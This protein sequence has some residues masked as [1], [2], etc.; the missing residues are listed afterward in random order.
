MYYVNGEY[1]EGEWDNDSQNGI[2]T[3]YNK[4]GTIKEY[5]TWVDG[6]CQG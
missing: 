6:T 4:D 1:Y 5:G 3:M 2:G